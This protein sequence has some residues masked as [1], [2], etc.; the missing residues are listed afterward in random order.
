[1]SIES[2]ENQRDASE[3]EWQQL[4]EDAN[5]WREKMREIRESRTPSKSYLH[6]IGNLNAGLVGSIDG[7]HYDWANEDLKLIK[8]YFSLLERY[9]EFAEKELVPGEGYFSIDS[10]TNSLGTSLEE[11]IIEEYER[12]LEATPEK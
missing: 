3:S 8:R 1:M 2:S 9:P 12:R 6:L 4:R 7:G 5:F 10:T 11:P